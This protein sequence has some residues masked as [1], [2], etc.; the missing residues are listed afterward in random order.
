MQVGADIANGY[1]YLS[2]E[3]NTN[4]PWMIFGVE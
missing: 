3:P 2:D 4:A 1:D